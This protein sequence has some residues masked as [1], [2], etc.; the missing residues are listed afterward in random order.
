MY[1]D[2]KQ[3]LHHIRGI[4]TDTDRGGQQTAVAAQQGATLLDLL[5]RRS[6]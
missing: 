5:R 3:R 6:A 1:D 2:L 4:L